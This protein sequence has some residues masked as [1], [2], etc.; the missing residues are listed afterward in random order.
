MVDPLDEE[1]DEKR[2]R[3]LLVVRGRLLKRLKNVKNA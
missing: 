1:L 3:H 2:E